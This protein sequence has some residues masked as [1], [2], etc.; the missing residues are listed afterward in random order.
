MSSLL[1]IIP[2]LLPTPMRAIPS[3]ALSANTDWALLI[4][5]ATVITVN[6]FSV[7]TYDKRS[8]LLQPTVASGLTVGAGLTMQANNTAAA[9][10]LISAQI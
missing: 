10:I 5:S 2:F 1:A 6:G 7:F 3:V 4:A 9:K 8:L